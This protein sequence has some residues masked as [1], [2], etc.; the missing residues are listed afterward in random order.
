MARQPDVPI[1]SCCHPTDSSLKTHFAEVPDPEC[2]WYGRANLMEVNY[3][4]TNIDPLT[5]ECVLRDKG[6]YETLD[7]YI[8]EAAAQQEQQR[9]EDRVKEAEIDIVHP[10]VWTETPSHDALTNFKLKLLLTLRKIL[11]GE[12]S[13]TEFHAISALLNLT[14]VRELLEKQAKSKDVILD[15]GA[16][17]TIYEF[18]NEVI[19]PTREFMANLTEAIERDLSDPIMCPP[20]DKLIPELP[21]FDEYMKNMITIKAHIENNG[22]VEQVDNMLNLLVLKPTELFSVMLQHPEWLRYRVYYEVRE[23]I[24]YTPQHHEDNSSLRKVLDYLKPTDN[25]TR[26]PNYVRNFSHLLV[27][28]QN[29][30]R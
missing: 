25:I 22:G 3:D 16:I 2:E 5:L 18:V 19:P 23:L 11:V 9:Q 20:Y 7:M 13:C 1:E 28:I 26:M 17:K 27:A 29:T 8:A 14:E 10:I 4:D 24:K 15:S 12:I 30:T 21:K 6:E